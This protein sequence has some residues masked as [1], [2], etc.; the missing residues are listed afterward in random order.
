MGDKIKVDEVGQG[1]WHIWERR[2]AHRPEG[3]ETP[4][5]PGQRQKDDIDV[6]LKEMGWESFLD[7]VW[8]MIVRHGRLL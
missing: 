2:E 5:A 8:L 4:S 3:R 7:C 1:M 6:N